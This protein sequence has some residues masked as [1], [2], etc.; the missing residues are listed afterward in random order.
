MIIRTLAALALTALLATPALASDCS[1]TITT[2]GTAQNAVTFPDSNGFNSIN[3][4]TLCN[5]DATAAEP[6]WVNLYGTAA[7]ATPGSI[8]L[9]SPAATTYASSNSC[10]TMPS[11]WSSRVSVSVVA[12]TSGHR[13]SC[14]RW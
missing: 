10:L 7:A 6:L 8:P 5:I 12:A 2:G 11:G 1:G 4:F 3:N 14:W 13:F 9:A